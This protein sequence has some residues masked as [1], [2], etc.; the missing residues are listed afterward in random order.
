M[1]LKQA[2]HLILFKTYADL[3]AES[4]RSY[5]GLFW[6]IVEPAL[7]VI[8]LYVLFVKVFDRG[9]P[10]FVP[11]LLCGTI[12]WK[13]FASGLQGGTTSISA[14]SGL[15]QQIYVPKYVFP[16]VAV[17]G[18]TARFIPVFLLLLLFL[19]VYGT[20]PTLAWLGILVVIPTHFFFI[21]SLATLVGAITP[22]FPDIKFAISN[23]LMLLFFISG[24]F[25]NINDVADPLKSY[26]LLNPM[27]GLI[28]EYRNVML[29]GAWPN[30][31]R[32]LKI[33]LTSGIIGVI[34]LT[35]LSRLDRK[36]GKVRF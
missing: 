16:T 13:W 33:F 15:L 9:G 8:A 6:W 14:Y 5:L 23:G 34:A 26:L 32:L 36:Y 4:A 25:F 2:L 10:D 19:L 29:R 17:L 27:A 24:V 28:D 22:F 7:Y 3:K 35:L 1:N 11:F 18:S 20:T 31:G 21:L 30:I 12:T